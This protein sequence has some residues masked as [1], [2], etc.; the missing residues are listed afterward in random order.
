M[1]RFHCRWKRSA[2]AALHRCWHFVRE[3]VMPFGIERCPKDP[4]RSYTIL[5]P[6]GVPH[7]ISVHAWDY[8][9]TELTGFVP[10]RRSE[11]EVQLFPKDLR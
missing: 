11:I 2:G 4:K 3:T 7:D 1:A 10:G 6:D 8:R 9:S 5:L